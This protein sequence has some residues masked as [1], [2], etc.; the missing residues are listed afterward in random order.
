MGVQSTQYGARTHS[1]THAGTLPS[2]KHTTRHAPACRHPTT[3]KATE[4]GTHSQTGTPPPAK[5][6]RWART[7]TQAHHHLQS[8]RTRHAPARRH[9]T[10]IWPIK[11][12]SAAVLRAGAAAMLRLRCA[13]MLRGSVA[14]GRRASISWACLA[15]LDGAHT[16]HTHLTHISHTSLGHALPAWMVHTHLTHISHTSLGHALPAG[17]CTH[18]SAERGSHS[19]LYLS[20]YPRPEGS[21][22]TS[23]RLPMPR[24][25]ARLCLTAPILACKAKERST[26]PHAGTP[27]SGPARRTA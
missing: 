12:G 5:Q 14:R 15:C 19:L 27:P 25:G 6:K 21:P 10:T 17:W 9:T 20:H 22:N 13:A 7:R 24:Y 1:H 2:S 11:A 18:I 23:S 16:S 4:H 26:H 8:R 3:C